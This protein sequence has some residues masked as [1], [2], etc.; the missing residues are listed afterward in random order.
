MF[1]SYAPVG[2]T[3][4]AAAYCPEHKPDAP[5]DEIGAIAP[6]DSDYDWAC[7]VCGKRIGR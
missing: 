6:W 4:N 7:D 5:E 1:G 3:W 2:Y